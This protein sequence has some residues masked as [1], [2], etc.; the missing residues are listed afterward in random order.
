MQEAEQLQGHAGPG[1]WVRDT[2][3]ACLFFGHAIRNRCR[4]IVPAQRQEHGPYF[5]GSSIYVTNIGISA[6]HHN[7]YVP[8]YAQTSE[9]LIRTPRAL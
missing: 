1:T 4:K 9:L 2:F 8:E 6:Q 7:P 3:R 5:G